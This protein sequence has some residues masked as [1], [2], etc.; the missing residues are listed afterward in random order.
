MSE[1]AA[2]VVVG[3]GITGCS[4]AYHLAKAGLRDVLLLEKAELT[5]GSTCH[6]AGLVTQ[7]NPSPTMMRFRRYSV[8][9]YRELGVFDTR[10]EP[11]HRVEPREPRGARARRQPGP[12][13]RARRRGALAGRGRPVAARRHARVALRGDLDRGRRLGRP[14]HRHA[15]ARE[16]RSG[17]RRADR[18]RTPRHRDPARA[19]A[20]GDRRRD[21][22]RADRDGAGRERLRDLGAAGGGDGGGVHALGAGRPPAHRP[23][24]GGRARAASRDAVLPGSR[25]SRLRQVGGRRDPLRRLRAEPGRALGGRGAVGSR[26][27]AGSTGPRALRAAHGRRRA[28]L[29]LPARRG[30][31]RAHLPSRRDDPGRQSA[32]RADARGAGVLDG[33]RSLAQRLRRRRRPRQDDR[34]VDL[35]G[36]DR[37]RRDRLPRLA[38]RRVVPRSALRA[39]DGPR[40]LPLLL[41]P[42]LPVRRRRVG[43]AEAALAPA[44]T[45]PGSR[46]GLRDE[47]RV[48]A[49][50]LLRA[51]EAE[52]E[53]R[54][55]PAGVRVHEAALVR[56]APGGAR[57]LPRAGRD[58]RHDL[59]REDRG[60]RPGRAAPARAGRRQ[61]DRPAGRERRLHAVPERPRRDRR[62]T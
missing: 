40:G 55:R 28:A 41:P 39:G 3:G 51:G 62:R 61:P 22:R 27:R 42:P 57:G 38:L 33:R 54:R 35:R 53:G 14:A 13:D 59:V 25:Q 16:R 10:R 52:P 43:Q 45:A 12:R 18:D 5:S 46:R 60:L 23:R 50:G 2:I 49:R 36:R 20:R 44:R 31:R 6:A 11:P 29:P 47:E 26:G 48:G 32:P 21:R 9:L 4:V 37:A 8:E 34:R 15:H 1:R 7:F 24:R 17:A 58:H 56:A 19:V 30:R